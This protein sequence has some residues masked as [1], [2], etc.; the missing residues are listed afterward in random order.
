MA[1]ND[2]ILGLDSIDW[3]ADPKQHCPLHISNLVES[4]GGEYKIYMCCEGFVNSY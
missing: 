4:L 1:K 2:V 3:I